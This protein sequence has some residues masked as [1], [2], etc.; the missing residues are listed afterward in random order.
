MYAQN[1]FEVMIVRWSGYYDDKGVGDHLRDSYLTTFVQEHVVAG[2][3]ESLYK[4]R[5]DASAKLNKDVVWEVIGPEIE[6]E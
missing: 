3:E 4:M 2:N 5:V 6:G 1:V